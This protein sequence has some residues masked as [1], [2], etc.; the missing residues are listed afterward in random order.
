VQVSQG[1]VD[2]EAAFALA[3]GA[4][5]GGA[6]PIIVIVS[7]GGLPES[8]LPSLPGDVRYVPIGESND[9]VAISALALRESRGKPQL[10]AGVK[11]YGDKNRTVI[12]SLYINNELFLARQMEIRADKQTSISLEGLPVEAGIYKAQ[13]SNFENLDAPLDSLAL[14]DIAFAIYQPSAARRVLLVSKGN[15]FLEQLLT[16]LPG[17][18]PFRTLPKEDG[19]LQIPNEPFDLYVFDGYIPEKLPT[20]NLLLINPKT[21]PLFEVG[22]TFKEIK[23]I[24]VREH[25]LTRYVD[26]KT[27][28]ILQARK[29]KP[30]LWANILIESDSNPLVKRAVSALRH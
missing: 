19:T 21:N 17:I 6:N 15:L 1:S 26:W 13:I 3:A 29:V 22:E 24:Q 30:P 27:V 5:H 20:G 8:G 11:N 9:N 2:W 25:T 14:D 18:Q 23:N 4:A 7:D 10:F 16:S 28:H 12:F